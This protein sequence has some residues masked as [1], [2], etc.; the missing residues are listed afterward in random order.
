MPATSAKQRIAMA[1]AEHEP[2]KLYARNRGMLKMSQG[3]L[4]DFASTKGL[5]KNGKRPH[6]KTVVTNDDLKQGYQKKPKVE[7]WDPSM[8]ERAV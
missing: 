1:I 4:H 8:A 6:N 5:P 7:W 3:Q 2:D